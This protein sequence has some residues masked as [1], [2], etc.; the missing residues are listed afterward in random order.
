MIQKIQLLR[1]CVHPQNRKT[2]GQYEKMQIKNA[3]IPIFDS[4]SI[5]D[6]MKPRYLMFCLINLI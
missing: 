1:D 4:Y 6:N 3:K 5:A 2:F